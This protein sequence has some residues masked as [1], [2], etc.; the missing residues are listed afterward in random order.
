[1]Q[2]TTKRILKIILIIFFLLCFLTSVGYWLYNIYYIHSSDFTTDLQ[3]DV[4]IMRATAHEV[5][6][7]QACVVSFLILALIIFVKF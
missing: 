7:F 6:A 4:D 5:A 3:K 1:M 2:K